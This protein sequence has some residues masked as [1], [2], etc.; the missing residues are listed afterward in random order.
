M[1]W[2][3]IDTDAVSQSTDSR[4]GPATTAATPDVGA[5]SLAATALV[6][7]AVTV[8]VLAPTLLGTAVTVGGGALAA[9]LATA[10]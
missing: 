4:H 9:I 1:G 7:L 5:D 8:V 6:T 10:A 2:A 3:S